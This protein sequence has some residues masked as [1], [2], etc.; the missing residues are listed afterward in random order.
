MTAAETPR[1][2]SRGKARSLDTGWSNHQ[3]GM[4][5]GI[6]PSM[7][8]RLRNGLHYPNV[9]QMKKF[10]AVF[11]WPASEQIDLLPLMLSDPDMRWSLVF[12]DILREWIDANPRTTPTDDLKVLART[13]RDGGGRPRKV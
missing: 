2:R 13:R 3:L 9:A 4:I 11:G 7:I 1:R 10:E 5:L 12:N 6:D 8:S